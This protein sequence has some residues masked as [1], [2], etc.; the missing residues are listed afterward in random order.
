V[1][2][3]DLAVLLGQWGGPGSADFDDNGVVDGADLAVLLGAWN[4]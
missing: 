1:S 3:A 2:G 4:G